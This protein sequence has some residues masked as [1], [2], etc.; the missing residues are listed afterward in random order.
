MAVQHRRPHG[1]EGAHVS[2]QAA[3]WAPPEW[4]SD[5]WTTPWAIVRALEAEFGEFDLDPCC[6]ALSAKTARYYTP[7]DDGL[8]LPWFGRVF[9]NP[10]YSNPGPWL[11]KAIAEQAPLVV[12]LL[13][14]CTDTAWFHELVLGR[15]EIRF[16]KGRVEFLAPRHK[17]AR[18][19]AP[20][21]F[22]I[23]R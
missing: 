17:I 18:P 6:T 5:H 7:V 1:A 15:A 16:I 4:S 22:A 9:L 2:E 21:M 8:A 3:L 11:A 12:A 13:P 10:P 20:S 14:V 23:Y 19:K